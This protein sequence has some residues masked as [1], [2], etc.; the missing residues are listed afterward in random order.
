MK[1]DY[2]VC[3]PSRF[4]R[5]QRLFTFAGGWCLERV[6]LS[7][8][9]QSLTELWLPQVKQEQGLLMA[10]TVIHGGASLNVK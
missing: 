3:L 9:D 6:V 1:K 2:L 4:R 5:A 8:M 10:I 7:Q